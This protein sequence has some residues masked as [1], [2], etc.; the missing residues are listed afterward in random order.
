MHEIIFYVPTLNQS[1][2][3][4]KINLLI[5]TLPACYDGITNLNLVDDFDK[6]IF[7]TQELPT[8]NYNILL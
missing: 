4:Q 7:F 6:K 1:I 5:Q 8:P 2:I 3:K